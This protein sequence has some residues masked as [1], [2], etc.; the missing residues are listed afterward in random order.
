MA[1]RESES[2]AQICREATVRIL[3]DLR[4]PM[5]GFHPENKKRPELNSRRHV[6]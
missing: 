6:Q 1:I 4:L 5:C 3:S 2:L